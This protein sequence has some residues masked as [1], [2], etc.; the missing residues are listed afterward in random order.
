MP[1]QQRCRR[2]TSFQTSSSEIGTHTARDRTWRERWRNSTLVLLL[3]GQVLL[4]PILLP[5]STY[6]AE[7]SQISVGETFADLTT[8][9]AP[10]DWIGLPGSEIEAFMA[11]M[12]SPS[13]DAQ[14]KV[15]ATE[16]ANQRAA[17]HEEALADFHQSVA[18]LRIP[19]FLGESKIF[20]PLLNNSVTG[21]EPEENM[22]GQADAYDSAG[23]VGLHIRQSGLYCLGYQDLMD[24]GVDLTGVPTG[25]LALNNRG[26]AIPFT[27]GGPPVVGEGTVIEFYGEAIDTLYTDNNVYYLNVDTATA[28]RAAVDAAAP[29]S[30]EPLTTHAIE[31]RT[32][33]P[34]LQ[35]SRV[36]PLA[37][38]WVEGYIYAG[39]TAASKDYTLELDHIV[40]DAEATE[41]S[42]AA[43]GAA[44]GAH[45][46]LL[47]LNDVQVDD[48]TFSDYA[49]YTLNKNI[50]TA[51]LNEGVNSLRMTL[52][53][54][55]GGNYDYVAFERMSISYPRTLTATDN[56]LQFTSAATRFRID[57]LTAPE[58]AVYRLDA[59]TPV[60]LRD[61]LVTGDGDTY[62][63]EFAGSGEEATYWVSTRSA[64]VAPE[65]ITIEPAVSD[66]VNGQA[67]FVIISH[68][69]FISTL[70]PFV[71]AREAQGY[72]VRVVDVEDIYATHS[73]GIFGAEAI[74][75]FVGRAIAEMGA[76]YFLLVGADTIDYHNYL[77]RG[78]VSFIP[79]LY[80]DTEGA[81]TFAPADP[82]YTD[83]DNNGRPD[84]AIGRW[85]VRTAGEAE[86]II[87]KTLAYD[88]KQYGGT[89]IRVHETGFASAQLATTVALE[90]SGWFFNVD[91]GA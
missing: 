64:C 41:L 8:P 35:Y 71:Q 4:G 46:I 6:A 53:A 90:N 84:A 22:S 37:D 3:V 65:L 39:N 33:N 51:L 16:L 9:T 60:Q 11:D 26:Q 23:G 10:G 25:E 40:G 21:R 32:L 44:A 79:S 58:L 57:G 12:E 88:S 74:Q 78:L 81:V 7:V 66:P 50:D 18:A 13:V 42:V 89:G 77:K 76:E 87:A 20:I 75:D 36:S 43:T 30:G 31:T 15:A 61:F 29:L 24:A 52:P 82:L 19:P 85:P 70:T 83:I 72:T 49:A 55:T 73:D 45:H 67:D 59:G 48:A 86:S 17:A 63:V 68:P 47:E 56:R 28:L 1:I 38:P 62:S 14:W 91:V 80:A 27:V 54:D 34:N 2:N 5:A 69:N